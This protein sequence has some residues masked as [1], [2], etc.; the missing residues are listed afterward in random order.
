M[1]QF[2]DHVNQVQSIVTA[3]SEGAEASVINSHQCKRLASLYKEI[4]GFVQQL[5][6]HPELSSPWLNE[7]IHLLE[8]GKI[9][10]L[11]YSSAQW[12]ELLFTRGNNQEA[13]KEIHYELQ[14]YMTSLIDLSQTK[15]CLKRPLNEEEMNS[16]HEKDVIEDH[17]EM[18]A[19]LVDLEKSVHIANMKLK[20]EN[21]TQNWFSIANGSSMILM[22]HMD[23][24]LRHLIEQRDSKPFANDVAI[25]IIFQIATGMAYLHNQGVF[26][27]DLKASNVLVIHRGGY[28]EVKIADFG[29]SQSVQLTR[30]RGTRLQKDGGYSNSSF[31]GTV[32]TTC[33]RAPEVFPLQG[34]KKKPKNIIENE[35]LRDRE[36]F[37]LH[38]QDNG[39]MSNNLS[40]HDGGKNES[41]LKE[42]TYTAKADVYSFGMTCYEILTGK[43]PFSGLQPSA[44][45]GKVLAGER[46]KLPGH[47]DTR[48]S[49]LIQMCWDTDAE[50]R[51]TFSEI[52]SCLQTL[53][54]SQLQNPKKI[55]KRRRIK[56]C[57]I[58]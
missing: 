12:F 52:C 4:S 24:D 8:K 42:P 51:P 16:F 43:T 25:D 21:P 19:K 22:E 55:P 23:G 46:P 27:G 54:V 5:C 37:A 38:E 48:L 32:G 15:V 26:H 44:V 17:A 30:P 56:Q 20:Q 10:V 9:L 18:L 13:F 7:L 3:I 45:Y 33:W 11:Q 6:E 1:E 53:K 57:T 29:V 36:K 39:G 40:P 14:P 31:S 49:S 47:I 34:R 35:T 28:I 41:S 58:S 50:K 2:Q